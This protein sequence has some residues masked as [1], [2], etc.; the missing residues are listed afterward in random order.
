MLPYPAEASRQTTRT[1]GEDAAEL[2]QE[3]L[4]FCLALLRRESP[5]LA[6]LVERL[7]G[8]PGV[9]KAGITA[10]VTAAKP[11]PIAA[12]GG[13]Q[14]RFGPAADDLPRS[15]SNRRRATPRPFSLVVSVI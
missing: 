13:R 3:N 15:R 11:N 9:V 6:L 14:E 8:L 7:D 10:M 1:A 4:A 5:D 2:A 12:R